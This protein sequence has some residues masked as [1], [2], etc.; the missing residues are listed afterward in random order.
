MESPDLHGLR[1]AWLAAQVA[2][3]L[4]LDAGTAD[5]VRDA[6]LTHDIGKRF[7]ARE[8]LDKPSRLN[9]LERR[10]VEMHV[11][12]GG[13][14]LMAQESG[15]TPGL[16]AQVALLHH[17]W[18]NG[19]GY[20]FGLSGTRIPLAARIVSV[21]DVFDALVHER[22]YKPAWPRAEVL[23]YLRTQRGRQFDPV[24]A[25]AMHDLG[26]TLPYDWADV[27]G[28]AGTAL[29]P[30]TAVRASLLVDRGAAFA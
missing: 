8:V 1:T 30:A 27:A 19:M 7:I 28:A 18:W 21:A 10:H 23:R 5:A 15:A 22:E 29:L 17:E 11:V 9:P 24:C 12:L 13:R 2:L 14:F 3:A 16:A 6:A 25:D 26:S 20:P 4:G